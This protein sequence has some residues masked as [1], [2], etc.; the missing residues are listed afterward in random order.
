[1]K[2]T[3]TKKIYYKKFNHRLAIICR[4]N[5]R[6]PQKPTPEILE[7]LLNIKFGKNNW[8]GITSSSYEGPYT[9]QRRPAKNLYTVFFKDPEVF[10]YLAGIVGQDSFDEYERPM[11]DKHTEML[12]REKVITRKILFHNKYRIAIRVPARKSTT[13]PGTTTKHLDE[14]EEWLTDNLG[15][16][17]ESQDIYM[18][19]RWT[20]G[21]FYF[22]NPK[23]AMLFKLVWG[24]YIGATE[25]VV[26]IS[27]MEEARKEE[28]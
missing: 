2:E 24:E 23:D 5:N 6:E 8:R 20:N 27:E 18:V 26:L 16:R 1:M 15:K 19:N 7:W 9:W 17:W 13:Y 21:T 22:T 25:R 11:D 28:A 3:F 12:E 14:M 10:T 4:K